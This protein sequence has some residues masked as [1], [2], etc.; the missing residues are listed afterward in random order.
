MRPSPS[1]LSN[2]KR[3]VGMAHDPCRDPHLARSAYTTTET[4]ALVQNSMHLSPNFES[5]ENVRL[6]VNLTHGSR[7]RNH[8]EVVRATVRHWK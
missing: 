5:G 2:N 7:C 3:S 8:W 6:A 1:C 4:T